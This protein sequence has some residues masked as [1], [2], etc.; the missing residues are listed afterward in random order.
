[1]TQEEGIRHGLLLCFEKKIHGTLDC[2][3]ALARTRSYSEVNEKENLLQPK[4]EIAQF[5]ACWV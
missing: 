2:S 3:V 5:M 4:L 1:M